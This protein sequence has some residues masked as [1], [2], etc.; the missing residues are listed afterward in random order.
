M[1][2]EVLDSNNAFLETL[3]NNIPGVII[4][5]YTYFA[6]G[7]GQFTYLS[8]NIETYSGYS[9]E[10]LYKNQEL[11]KA[12]IDAADLDQIYEKGKI[13]LQDL[14]LFDIEVKGMNVKGDPKY[15]HFNSIPFR[16]LNG[17]TIWNGILT[18]TTEKVLVDQ[19]LKR[20]ISELK[21]INQVSELIYNIH[22]ELNLT[23]EVCKYLVEFGNYE[24]V[25]I[26]VKPEFDA[27]NQNVKIAAASGKT[28]YTKD[29]NINLA[30]KVQGSGPT[31]AA[32]NTG[33]TTVANNFKLLKNFEFWQAKADEYGLKG[34]VSIALNFQ[35]H[36]TGNINIYS[37][38]INSFDDQEVKVLETIAKNLSSAVKN[39]R[40]RNKK[41]QTRL[42]LS[43]RIKEL[44]VL[45][46]VNKLLLDDTHERETLL[47]SVIN[48][49][50]NA[51]QYDLA[52]EARLKCGTDI[53]QSIGYNASENFIRSEI[54]CKDYPESYIEVVYPSEKDSSVNYIFLKEE[55]FLLNTI[56]E[57][58]ETHFKKEDAYKLLNKSEAN[59][60]SI[61]KNT[62]IG[63][64]LMD[65]NF[66]IKS[67]NKI[68][69]KEY[70][71]LTG[72]QIKVGLN[73]SKLLQADR[74]EKFNWVFEKIK[75]EKKSYSYETT[76]SNKSKIN[77]FEITAI[78]V[79]DEKEIIG[80]CISGQNISKRKEME[81]AILNT[82]TVLTRRNKDLEQFAFIVSHNLRAP[83]ANIVA[84]NALLKE[85][86]DPIEKEEILEKIDIST[87][88]LENVIV[89]LNEILKVKKDVSEL[90]DVFE[91]KDLLKDVKDIL[92]KQIE[93]SKI[94]ISFDF[95]KCEKIGSIRT[96][97]NSV[98]Y[99]LISNSMKYVKEGQVPT[100]R[101]WSEIRK[102]KV[103]LHFKDNGIGIDMK[104]N[105]SQLFGLYKRF[106]NNTD[107]N[108]IGLYM[109]KAQL[110]SMG[111]NIVAESKPDE[112]A[113]FIIT[114]PYV[115][116]E[117]I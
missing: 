96:Y 34:C 99:N 87:E 81:N 29:I 36:V 112:G 68:M 101:I 21:L 107:G 41:E 76:Y 98:F 91:F 89:D 19:K 69:L 92:G 4:Y 48:L 82:N 31:A 83:V 115:N 32:L 9:L 24:L 67:Y 23:Q 43:L 114:L 73:F 8:K 79:L 86:N 15:F 72:F 35:K 33:I 65:T 2:T 94:Q 46:Q 18:D 10:E 28:G 95:S 102:E 45:Q 50:P 84:L 80:Y 42:L 88:R 77:Y 13:S 16:Q 78:P 1:N 58:L 54:T 71:N 11:L 57:M 14:S 100:L 20:T 51:F 53:Y 66:K 55:R 22:D 106:N 109:V 117:H 90:N 17:N 104:K 6:E 110:E 39:I 12:F 30:D 59:M 47:R 56:A 103:I 3:S 75:R 63:Y 60:S 113:E 62:E 7:Y 116:P 27:E 97:L 108:G 40:I 38:S 25:W 5:Q 52:C 93:N 26:G 105:G 44:D 74:K 37:N 49:I 61:F 111:G 70:S 85:S 64:L